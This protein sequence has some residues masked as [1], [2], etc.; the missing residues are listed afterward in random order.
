[1]TTEYAQQNGFIPLT[2][3]YKLPREKW[4]LDNVIRDAQ[5][6]KREICL[7]STN[8]GV[9]VWQRQKTKQP[10]TTQE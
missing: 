10:Q 4:M 1:M 8:D 9:E 2:N 6:N 3:G 7:V 5:Q